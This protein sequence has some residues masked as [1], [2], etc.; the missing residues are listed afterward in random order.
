MLLPAGRDKCQK[1]RF[2]TAKRIQQPEAHGLGHPTH[3]TYDFTLRVAAS[4]S[5]VGFPFK[6]EAALERSSREMHAQEIQRRGIPADGEGGIS[7][8]AS[9]ATEVRDVWEGF[10][11]RFTLLDKLGYPFSPAGFSATGVVPRAANGG[12]S[13]TSA[14]AIPPL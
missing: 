10:K 11:Y 4:L 13:K 5:R 1:K 9:V 14:R 12:L 3:K 6:I 7:T 2:A 8:T